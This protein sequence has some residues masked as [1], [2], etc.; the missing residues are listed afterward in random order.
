M[1]DFAYL[2]I[3]NRKKAELKCK[4]EVKIRHREREGEKKE[5]KPIATK[6]NSRSKLLK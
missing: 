6:R 3:E 1:G 2:S 4:N 5:L